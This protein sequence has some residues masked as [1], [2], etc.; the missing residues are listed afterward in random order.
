MDSGYD[1]SGYNGVT[2]SAP[3]FTMYLILS[4]AELLCCSFITGI[5]ALILTIMANS[6]YKIGNMIDYQ[7][8]MKISKILLIVG[9]CIGIIMY[10]LIFVIFF[11]IGASTLSIISY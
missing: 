5:I 6:A 3:N 10:V 9:L 8:K 1:N 4:I 2:P 11:V 7:S